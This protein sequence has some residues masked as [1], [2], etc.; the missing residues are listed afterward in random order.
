MRYWRA[1]LLLTVC[2]SFFAL[3]PS[4]AALTN[5]EIYETQDSVDPEIATVYFA[6]TPDTTPEF[7]SSYLAVVDPNRKSGD[8]YRM[9]VCSSTK[10]PKCLEKK[11]AWE[12]RA[13]Y[14][15]CT[16]SD[17]LNCIENFYAINSD[18]KKI[19]AKFVETLP[20]P[21]TFAADPSLRI[22][23]GSGFTVW[24]I[25]GANGDGS[26]LFG[27]IVG[28]HGG[29]FNEGRITKNITGDPFDF[30]A[31]IQPITWK[32]LPTT[33]H[34]YWRNLPAPPPYPAGEINAEFGSAGGSCQVFAEG[35]CGEKTSFNSDS[36]Y[37]ITFRT[38][39]KSQ[40]WF[41]GRMNSAEV[42]VSSISS[43]GYKFNIEGAPTRIPILEGQT[44]YKNV[45]LKACGS[46][47]GYGPTF[48]D[49]VTKSG[50]RKM[51]QGDS[52]YWANLLYE[53]WKPWLDPKAKAIQT[54]W[55][56][57]SISQIDSFRNQV[58]QSCSVN[59][60]LAGFVTTNAS[61]Y[62]DGP[63]E[64]NELTNSLE[65]KV[66]AP[67]FDP[68]GKDLVGTYS[69]VMDEK[70][71][72]CIYKM[73][74]AP[75]SATVEVLSDDGE[76]SVATSSLG[77]ENGFLRLSATG[78]HYSAPTIK[79][80]FEQ[81]KP[82]VIPTPIQSSPSTPTTPAPQITTQAATKVITS[83]TITCVKGKSIRK[84]TGINPKC[85]IGYKKK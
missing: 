13:L 81:P 77:I 21:N 18:G 79:V 16:T 26:N 41:R 47:E 62:S 22:P 25:D 35:R 48:Q 85:P 10:D 51:S 8:L 32:P 74:S 82:V 7:S 59:L 17:S 73:T 54:R 68:N 33:G 39:S 4:I 23:Q 53:C 15:V 38:S 24:Q 64:W 66:A 40:P 14:P 70:V 44:N 27:V 58:V 72:K 60:P 34:T 67:H 61:I 2:L 69:L 80:K 45:P 78:F 9:L 11:W 12:Y 28:E 56:F 6:T 57:N 5:S 29:E 19:S 42:S 30:F 63:P 55:N 49:F 36:R 75:I 83:K 31:G 71:A 76:Q 65:Y 50:G 43:G 84:I 1:S 20:S 3:S 37:G 46:Y 52:G